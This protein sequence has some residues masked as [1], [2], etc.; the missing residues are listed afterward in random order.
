[1]EEDSSLR[2]ALDTAIATR[3]SAG[4]H[5]I[6]A[7]F[8]V[9][10]ATLAP[11]GFVLLGASDLVGSASSRATLGAGGI[12]LLVIQVALFSGLALRWRRNGVIPDPT[13]GATVRQRWNRFWLTLIALACYAAI[14][15]VTGR[16][17]WAL[18]Y[19]GVAL[20]AAAVYGQRSRRNR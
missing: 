15:A 10:T 5:R 14:W 7:A 13:Q 8:T 9:A 20:G 6:P 12:I 11:T 2:L 4:A 17:G 1:M 18:I 19:A 16:T 3:Q